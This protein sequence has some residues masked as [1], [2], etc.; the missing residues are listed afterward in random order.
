MPVAY[1]DADWG[2]PPTDKRRSTSGYVFLINGG[3]I[4]WKSRKQTSTALSSNEAEY[5]AASEAA[6][7]TEWLYRLLEA[8]ELYTVPLQS[9]SRSI[10][11]IR[12]PKISPSQRSRR[13]VPNILYPLLLY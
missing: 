8:M 9:T 13:T 1:T 6:R 5:M 10:S 7:E 2:G 12:A 3:P 11:T 4:S